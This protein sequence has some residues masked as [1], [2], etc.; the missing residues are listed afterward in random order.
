MGEK[1]LKGQVIFFNPIRGFGFIQSDGQEYF[2]HV[3]EL[4]GKSGTFRSLQE[5]E[6][7]SFIPKQETKGWAAKNVE[8]LEDE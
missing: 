5:H 3:S 7:V 8:I 4:I 2:V 1:R 6:L